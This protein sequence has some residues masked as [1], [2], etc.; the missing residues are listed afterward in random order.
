MELNLRS[1]HVRR[2]HLDF[3]LSLEF[4]D[5]STV[6]FSEFSVDGVVYDEDNQ[7]EGLRRVVELS[8]AACTSAEISNDGGLLIEFDDGTSVSAAPRAEVESWEFTG[9]DGALVV[10][11]A[12]G[13]VETNDA[14]SHSSPPSPV[15]GA[16]A[17]GSTVVRLTVGRGGGIEFSNGSVLPIEVPLH[18]AYLILRETVV[19]VVR[20]DGAVQVK[21]SSGLRLQ[22]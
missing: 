16:I 11:L 21:L 19:S 20:S 17:E 10:C 13:E 7:F 14:T 4:D 5:G 6:A 8:G 18:D 22:R 2:I 9:A 3:D 12:G 15:P 1:R